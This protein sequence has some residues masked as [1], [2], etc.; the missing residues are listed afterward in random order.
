M[1]QEHLSVDEFNRSLGKHKRKGEP[2]IT[3]TIYG[4]PVPAGSKTPWNPRRKDGTLVLRADGRPVI[5]TMDSTKRKGGEWK[6]AIA[7]AARDAYEGDLLDGPL[8]VVIRFFRPR[9]KG[10]FGKR[11]MSKAGMESV[12]P[13]TKPD[14]LKLARAVEDALTGVVWRDDSQIVCELL[15][16]DWGEPARCEV[17][18]EPFTPSPESE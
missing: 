1:A 10:H 9:P 4:N 14:V 2:T 5:A 11:G 17:T 3:I 16:K 6:Q 8:R 12:A 13:T 7:A 18:I 15:S